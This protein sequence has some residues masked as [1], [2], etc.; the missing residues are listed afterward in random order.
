MGMNYIRKITV[1]AMI[2]AV[3]TAGF[4]LPGCKI[5]PNSM[6]KIPKPI[7]TSPI[8]QSGEKGA[9]TTKLNIGTDL[10]GKPN[11]AGKIMILMYHNIG[12]PESEWVRTPE[13]FRK[14]LE[15]LY[16]K[17]YQPISLQDYV[18]GE[19]TIDRGFTPFVL[20]FDDGNQNNF[21]YLDNGLIRDDSAV[22]ILLDFHKT[23]PDFPLEATFFITGGEPFCQAGLGK[24]KL[25]FLIEQGMDVGNHT[26]DH[27]NFKRAS[28][29]EL[30][31]QIGSQAQKLGEMISQKNYKINSIALPFGIRPKDSA[32]V[33]YM[34][35]GS[36]QGIPYENIAVLNVGWNPA[37]SPYDKRFDFRSIP[38]IRA[39][40]INVDQVGMYQYLDYFD[41]NSEERF[42]S[43]GRS[44]TITVPTEKLEDLGSFPD[45]QVVLY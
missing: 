23:H 3:L 45:K 41:K 21:D 40:E 29:E 42:I 17:G 32:L 25:D 10:F 5:M 35:S 43:D 11:E 33:E 16:D 9:D 6:G 12:E 30:Q 22:G 19:I 4:F 31:E 15:I 34:V 36:F 14:D 27:P 24:K 20:T 1:F 28:K 8:Q 13:N 2:L 18:S 37:Y 7:Q 39:S 38:R 44:E 26:K